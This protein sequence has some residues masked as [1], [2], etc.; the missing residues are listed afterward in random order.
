MNVQRF[1]LRAVVVNF[2]KKKMILS[3]FIHTFIVYFARLSLV[4]TFPIFYFIRGT[5][6]KEIWRHRFHH[7]TKD[8][9]LYHILNEYLT[10]HSNI[11]TD[12][13]IF[14]VKWNLIHNSH[15]KNLIKIFQETKIDYTKRLQELNE[16][17]EAVKK[18]EYLFR[19]SYALSL[20][21]DVTAWDANQVCQWLRDISPCCR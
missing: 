8:I 1:Q 7:C 18:R 17:E 10:K 3:L 12:L 4:F 20:H 13:I 16:R 19:S 14:L 15:A 9:N 6:L 2:S 21:D 5:I 11:M